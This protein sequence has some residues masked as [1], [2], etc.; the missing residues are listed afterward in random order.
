MKLNKNILVKMVLYS[1]VGMLSTGLFL[2]KSDAASIRRIEGV[3][4]YQ[5]SINVADHHRS[6]TAIVVNGKDFPDALSAVSL[7]NKFK[8]NII[9]TRPTSDDFQYKKFTADLINRN[10]ENVIIIGG[11]NSVDK[12]YEIELSKFFKVERIQGN[13][14]YET[15]MKVVERSGIKKLCITDGRNF[16][17]ALSTSALVA[18]TNS[19]LLLIDGRKKLDLDKD[20][21]VLYTVGGTNSIQNTYGKR[22]AGP[23]RYQTCNQILDL[24]NA[25]NILIAS[26]RDFPDALS[27]A[28][29]ASMIDTGLLLCSHRVDSNVVERSAD[30]DSIVVV[31]GI[32]SVSGLTVNSIMDKY[33]YSYSSSEDVGF[34]S[35]SQTYRF[36]DGRL[37]KGWLYQPSRSLYGYDKYYYNE[38]GILERDK[39]IAGVRLD[40]DGKAIIDNDGKTITN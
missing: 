14:R 4:R 20:Y 10:I 40:T 12:G 30:K 23:D 16:P 39:V 6:D 15:S 35:A 37:F 2:V 8:A 31:G 25:K 22:I 32:N 7:A 3:D 19:A 9:L 38:E 17:D 18:K 34:D 33:H 5:T 1:L 11:E 36:S 21:R 13:D 28:S 29:M 27:A 24:M 26:G